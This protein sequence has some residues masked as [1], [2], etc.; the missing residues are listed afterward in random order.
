M[1]EV[2]VPAAAYYGAQTARAVRNFPIGSVTMPPAFIHALGLLKEAAARANLE[3]GTLDQR[4]AEAIT[5]AASEIASG[6]F[7]DQFPISVYQTG[8]GTSSNMNANEVIAARANEILGGSRSTH[9][10]VHPNDHVNKGQSSNDII[11][12]AI[13]LAAMLEL[14][15]DL[16]PALQE[17]ETAL[18]AKACEFWPVIKT[19]RTHLQ[20]ATPIRLGQEFLGF[21]DAVKLNAERCRGQIDELGAVA[22]GGTAVGTGINCDPRFPALVLNRIAS[23]TGLPIRETEHHFVAQSTIDGM[24]AASGT[25]RAL[26]V[27]L[28]KIANDVRWMSSGPR[29]GLGEIELPELQPGSSIMP[30]KVNPVAAEAL[31]MVAAQVMGFDV[32]VGLAGQAGNFELNVMLPVVAN[33]LLQGIDLL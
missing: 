15:N 23:E 33:D 24:V 17:L 16:I 9:G 7:D 6:G 3:L 5:Q 8:S 26:A 25:L 22:L 12:T 30:G 1:G 31:V 19:G 10:E 13:H 18:R 20:D 11:P 14:K 2:E 21:A 32:T 28:T 27:A 29:A 4:R